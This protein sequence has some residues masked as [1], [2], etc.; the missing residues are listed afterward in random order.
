MDILN[1]PQNERTFICLW[2]KLRLQM[3]KATQSQQAEA[4]L[5]QDLTEAKIEI[6][7]LKH[8]QKNLNDE[9][10]QLKASLSNR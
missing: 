1:I 8:A 7:N 10:I 4:K 2:N 9:N 5:K 3:D 6:H